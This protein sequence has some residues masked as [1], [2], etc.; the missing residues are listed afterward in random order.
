MYINVH[1]QT[2]FSAKCITLR[3][4]KSY[5]GN[6][7]EDSEDKFEYIFLQK[8]FIFVVFSAVKAVRILVFLLQKYIT[9]YSFGNQS[10]HENQGFLQKLN[11][12]STTDKRK[13]GIYV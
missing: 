6:F 1:A 11:N 10:D 13:T 5:S 7:P 9:S 8:H 3:R 2:S 4:I 12:V